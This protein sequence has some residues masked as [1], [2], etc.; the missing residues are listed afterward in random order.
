MR[1]LRKIVYLAIAQSTMT[2]TAV[3]QTTLLNKKTIKNNNLE[4]VTTKNSRLTHAKSN[5]S[6]ANLW[7]ETTNK[8]GYD[9]YLGLSYYPVDAS[10]TYSKTAY[11]LG[12]DYD[13]KKMGDNSTLLIGGEVFL[14][15]KAESDL[16]SKVYEIPKEKIKVGTIYGS[17]ARLMY[18]FKQNIGDDKF[19][20]YNLGVGIRVYYHSKIDIDTFGFFDRKLF[21]VNI[22]PVVYASVKYHIKKVLFGAQAKYHMKVLN[23]QSEYLSSNSFTGITLFTG[24][25]FSYDRKEFFKKHYRD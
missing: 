7:G 22:R 25:R 12:L 8:T 9:L 4:W 23:S 24:L 15:G 20:Q 21:D 16:Y 1:H 6:L 14:L 11:C 10:S 18:G 17:E 2:M 13:I 19:I 3:G 5:S